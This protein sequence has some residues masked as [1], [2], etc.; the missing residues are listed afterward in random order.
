MFAYSNDNP[1]NF[2]DF[3]VTEPELAMGWAA[4]MSWLPAI[5]GPVPVGDTINIYLDFLSTLR[6][7]F[8][9]E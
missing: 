6:T 4:S 3:E 5:D 8:F 2:K 1:V 7:I 9:Q